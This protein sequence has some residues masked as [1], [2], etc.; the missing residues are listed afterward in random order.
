MSYPSYNPVKLKYISSACLVLGFIIPFAASNFVGMPLGGMPVVSASLILLWT[1]GL[2][3]RYFAYVGRAAPSA[4]LSFGGIGLFISSEPSL[5]LTM[6]IVFGFLFYPSVEK[7][8]VPAL[9]RYLLMVIMFTMGLA[10][11][12]QQWIRMVQ[13]PKTVAVAVL[14]KWASTPLIAFL[15]SLVLVRLFPG[16]TGNTLALGIIIAGTTPNGGGSNALTL[17]SK[18][19]LALSVSATAINTM[20]APFIQPLLILWLAGGIAGPS[21]TAIFQD[22]LFMVVVPVLAG[23]LLGSL[24]PAPASRMKPAFGPLAV[25]CLTFIVMGTMSRGTSTLIQQISILLYL[26]IIC[27]VKA[28]AGLCLGYFLPALFGFSYAQR[29]ATCFEVGVENA[30]MAM[31]VALRHFNPVTALPAIVYG[32]IQYVIASTVVV[33]RFQKIEDKDG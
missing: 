13:R 28:V 17:I 24:F 25:V 19:D 6:G 32:K 11:N 8:P 33:S 2:L 4:P 29:K 16:D 15:L 31:L 26:V 23:T 14:L 22:L 1:M 27:L 5:F 20:L 12:L 10:I 7:S 3:L 21:V 9:G 18:G 30:A